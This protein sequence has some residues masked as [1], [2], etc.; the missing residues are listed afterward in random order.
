VP[1]GEKRSCPSLGPWP[2]GL[3]GIIWASSGTSDNRNCWS[4]VEVRGSSG[5]GVASIAPTEGSLAS[6]MHWDID[7]SGTTTSDVG[8]GLATED[9]LREASF[10]GWDFTDVWQIDEGVSYPC[11][12]WQSECPVPETD[13]E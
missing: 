12:Q 9:M 7:A 2:G 8:T 5:S 1:P 11:L 4:A 13:P 10:D 3:I 6:G